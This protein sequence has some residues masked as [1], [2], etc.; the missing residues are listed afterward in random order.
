[1]ASKSK[2]PT[3]IKRTEKALARESVTE[4]LHIYASSLTILAYPAKHRD[5]SIGEDRM[6]T[7]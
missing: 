5:Y 7:A 6:K 1:M 3:R 2:K 4:N